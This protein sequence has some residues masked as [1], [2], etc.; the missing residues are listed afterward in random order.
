MPH[1]VIPNFQLTIVAFP[2]RPTFVAQI[3]EAWEV[4]E[5]MEIDSWKTMNEVGTWVEETLGSWPLSE[6][7]IDSSA[8]EK[9]ANVWE[10]LMEKV[11]DS[12]PRSQP[13]VAPSGIVKPIIELP[14]DLV[15]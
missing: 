11:K 8:R 6:S 3:S 5:E 12:P 15:E 1:L 2:T 7:Q 4:G 10:V 9:N 13:E 14:C